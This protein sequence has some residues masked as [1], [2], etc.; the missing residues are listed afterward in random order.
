MK[1]VVLIDDNE[2]F[3]CSLEALLNESDSFKCLNK[4]SSCESALQEIGDTKPEIILLDIRLSSGNMTGI[5][6]VK[7][8]K[9]KL[10]DT[11][12]VMLTAHEDDDYIINSIKNGASGYLL[13]DKN[14]TMLESKLQEVITGE[15][16]VSKS[17]PKYLTDYIKKEELPD[18]FT[19][20]E[21]EI[22]KLLFKGK[23]YKT[24]ACILFIEITTVKF[25]VKNI[26]NKLSVS[27]KIEAIIKI[28]E[29][30]NL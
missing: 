7:L 24:I 23:S 10:P 18:T 16:P 27:N 1:N 13:K 5:E 6:G 12:V 14:I 20:R 21:K 28:T 26:Y 8:I 30:Y 29:N 25:H 9:K 19:R 22:I 11:L 15:F 4:Y 3:C 17:I 2:D